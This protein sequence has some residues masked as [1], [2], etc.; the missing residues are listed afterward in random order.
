MRGTVCCVVRP[1][2]LHYLLL[3]VVH[4]T[5]V[6]CDGGETSFLVSSPCI[7]FILHFSL[8]SSVTFSVLLFSYSL[9]YFCSSPS[10]VYVGKAFFPICVVLLM[11]AACMLLVV[12]WNCLLHLFRWVGSPLPY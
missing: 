7:I 6:L 10:H 1:T 3:L 4:C 9:M 11:P 5:N 8:I 12:E 2:T